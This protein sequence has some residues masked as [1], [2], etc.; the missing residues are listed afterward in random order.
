VDKRGT[1][2][3][4][5]EADDAGQVDERHAQP[6]LALYFDPQ[7]VVVQVYVRVLSGNVQGV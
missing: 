2:Q 5:T 6:G 4:I 7:R 3:D 1:D